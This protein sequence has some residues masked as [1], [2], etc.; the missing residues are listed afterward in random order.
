M[1]TETTVENKISFQKNGNEIEIIG[2]YFDE[3]ISIYNA[4]GMLEYH[5]T[6]HT[7]TLNP[8]NVYILHTTRKTMRFIF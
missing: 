4:E 5:G 7:V 1:I 8:N 2:L 6:N 3:V